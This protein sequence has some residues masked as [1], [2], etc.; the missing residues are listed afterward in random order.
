MHDNQC[1][2]HP[3]VLSGAIELTG[4]C[5]AALIACPLMLFSAGLL[6]MLLLWL[7]L[8]VRSMQLHAAGVPE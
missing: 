6:Q 7:T 3:Y 5:L 4:Q 1:K 8:Y 2:L